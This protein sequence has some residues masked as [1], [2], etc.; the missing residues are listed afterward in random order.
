MAHNH[1][2][3]EDSRLV[4]VGWKIRKGCFAQKTHF[5]TLH[6]IRSKQRTGPPLPGTSDNPASGSYQREPA[7]DPQSPLEPEPLSYR[8]RCCLR[9]MG[10]S[11]QLPGWP[12]RLIA[13]HFR[14]CLYLQVPLQILKLTI[15]TFRQ[16]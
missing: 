15:S 4:V 7:R 10:Q 11:R 3:Y 5:R 8:P 12:L 2:F 1:M 16:I 6:R 9:S 13:L 14:V